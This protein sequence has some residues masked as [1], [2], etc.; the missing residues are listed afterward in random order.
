MDG[1]L[2]LI[3]TM[4]DKH[5]DRDSIKKKFG[6]YPERIVDYLALVG[7]SADNIPGVEKVGPKTAVKWLDAYGDLDGVM[8][9]AAF[10][11]GKVGEHLRKALPNLPLYRQLVT[12]NRQ[13]L[14][15][16]GGGFKQAR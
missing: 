7:D 11:T 16:L 3:D 9:N 4:Y 6:V 10:M 14:C 8:R 5:Y 12:I 15:L 13:C 1:R 2:S